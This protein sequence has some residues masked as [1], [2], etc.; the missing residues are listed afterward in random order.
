MKPIGENKLAFFISMFKIKYRF[1]KF[2]LPL[3]A[4][5]YK[6]KLNKK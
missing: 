4:Q 3:A 6:Y 5:K 2:W 1:D